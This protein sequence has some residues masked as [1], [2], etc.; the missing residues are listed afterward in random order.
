MTIASMWAVAACAAAP[1]LV[2]SSGAAQQDPAAVLD[3]AVATYANV[4]TAQGTFEQSITNPLTGTANAARGDFVQQ[5]PSRLSVRFTEPAGDRIVADGKWVW[6]YVPSSAPGQVIRM[7]V[8][9]GRTSP[10]AGTVSI[11]FITQFLSGPTNRYVVTGAGPDTVAGRNTHVIVLVPRHAEQIVKAKLWVDDTDG[12]VR[13][14]EV[15]DQSGTLRHVRMVKETFNGP[16]DHAAF[17]FTPP[18]GVKV[19]NQ[20]GNVSASD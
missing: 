12:V 2:S 5:R 3:R 11:D 9:D 14:F 4:T 6:V 7:P 10:A 1:L 17:S 13:Q 20:T 19:V 18:P 16:V 15:T 8:S